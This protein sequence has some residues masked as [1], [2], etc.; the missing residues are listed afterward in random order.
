MFGT[1]R[2]AALAL[3]ILAPPAALA[4]EAVLTVSGAVAAPPE[5]DVWTFDMAALQALPQVSFDTTTIWT[6]GG[7]SFTGV[8]LAAL[9]EHVGA[10]GDSLRAVALND[11]AVTIPTSDAVEGGPIVAYLRNGAEMSVREKGPLW[12]MYPFDG[13]DS[14]KSEEYYARSI[15]QLSQIEFVT[16]Q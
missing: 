13:N 7:Q 1:I 6:E 4:Q 11:Y 14:Y 12:I 16:S 15:W 8:S 2:K 9:M 5:G 10:S 3:L